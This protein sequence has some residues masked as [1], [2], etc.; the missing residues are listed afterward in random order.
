MEVLG[1]LQV[2]IMKFIWV[3]GDSI[4][5]DVHTALNAQ[6]GV[7]ELAYTTILTVMRNLVRREM[8]T[9]TVTGLRSHTFTPT[10]TEV[11]YKIRLLKEVCVEFFEDDVDTMIVLLEEHKSGE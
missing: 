3:H 6:E 8:L 5:H 1:S 7:P 10:C 2:R 11:A 9:Q 4:V